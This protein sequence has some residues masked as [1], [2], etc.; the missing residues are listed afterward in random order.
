MSVTDFLEAPPGWNRVRLGSIS[1]RRQEVGFS[2]LPLLS[3]FLGEGVIPR[4]QRDDAATGLDQTW[5]GTSVR[6]PAT[7]F[8]TS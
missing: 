1:Y 8:S 5:A 6:C 2:N 7:S 4:D 3:V